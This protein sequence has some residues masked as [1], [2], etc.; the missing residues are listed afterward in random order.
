MPE[1]EFVVLPR[2]ALFEF[3]GEMALPPWIDE[4][5][6][7]IGGGINC[8]PIAQR[9]IEWVDGH[10]LAPL[11]EVPRSDEGGTA[12]HGEQVGGESRSDRGI[13]NVPPSSEPPP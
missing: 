5:G 7:E 4:R 8:A 3:L 2:D 6:K 13:A 9:L 1:P 10:D 12:P 11:Y